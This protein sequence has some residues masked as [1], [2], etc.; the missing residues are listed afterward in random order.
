MRR[1]LASIVCC[2]VLVP[3]SA[4]CAVVCDSAA[5]ATSSM[6]GHCDEETVHSTREPEEPRGAEAPCEDCGLHATADRDAP[7]GA[8]RLGGERGSDLVSY[9]A[10]GSFVAC[11]ARPVGRLT[12]PPD[13]SLPPPLAILHAPLLI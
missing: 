2:F 12:V 8:V 10:T 7:L 1:L 5:A 3:A 4:T 13:D 11:F 6:A 9:V